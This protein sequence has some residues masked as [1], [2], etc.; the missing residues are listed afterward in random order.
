VVDSSHHRPAELIA[1]VDQVLSGLQLF[2]IPRLVVWN[3]IDLLPDRDELLLD[4]RH[5][6]ALA[7]SART[8][9][10]LPELLG[11]IETL[12]GDGIPVTTLEIPYSRYDLV[13]LVYGQ[14]T[15]LSKE[16]GPEGIILRARVPL[17]L[18]RRLEPF[19]RGTA[20]TS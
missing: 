11:R 10:G 12:L 8:G 7:V 4:G 9:K 13:K 14:G 5:E 3:K 6:H 16:D 15:V 18:E 20:R 2:A 17:A 1:A 19:S